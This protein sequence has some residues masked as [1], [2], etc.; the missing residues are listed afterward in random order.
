MSNEMKLL[1]AL[2]DAMGFSVE[3][4]LDYKERE[5]GKD[6]AQKYNKGIG[7]PNPDGRRLRCGAGGFG[8][9]LERTDKGGYI[10]QL[11]QPEISY[12]VMRKVNEVS[13]DNA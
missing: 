8:D 11:I 6:A 10:S 7:F 2:C 4:I 5:E 13:M 3:T 1:M 9:M 12:R